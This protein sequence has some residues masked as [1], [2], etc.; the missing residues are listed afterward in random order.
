MQNIRVVG[1][2]VKKR[3]RSFLELFKNFFIGK[4]ISIQR[5][6]Y[7]RLVLTTYISVLCM[8]VAIIYTILDLYN[9]VYFSLIAYAVLLTM[10][11]VCLFLNRYRKYK[12]AKI[13]LMLSANLVVFWAAIHDPFETGVFLFFIT[14]GIGSFAILGF[15]DHKTG[16]G[17]AALTSFLFLLAYSGKF[18]H[19]QVERPSNEY[20]RVSLAFN[21]FISLTICILAVYF[22]M[23]LNKVSESELMEKET[24][25]NQKNA[26][27]QKVNDELDRFVY[28]VSHDLRSP[29]SSI[30]GLI[31]IGK[32]TTDHQEVRTI[33]E[34]IQGRVDAQDRFIREI[35]DYSRNARTDIHHEPVPLEPLVNEIVENLKY[36]INGHGIRFHLNIPDNFQMVTDRTRLSVILSNLIGNAIKY[37][38]PGKEQPFIEIGVQLPGKTLYVQD[39]GIGMQ[40]E[41]HAKIFDMFYRGSDRSK[42]SGLGLFISREA[43]SKLGGSITVKS[44]IEE[45]STFFV[46]LP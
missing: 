45:G 2:M 28:S 34:M 19:F 42:G 9:D 46:A 35:I 39:N 26:E 37:H 6:E 11:A 33:L 8:C 31:S 30:L 29:L 27:L 18:P 23:N 22:L 17:L 10:P 43:V 25:A 40:P 41:H 7:K 15:E 1:K 12:A 4:D 32:M 24:L 16:L 20:I 36:N 14:A 21:Y 44:V 3:M 5:S 13:L 38:D